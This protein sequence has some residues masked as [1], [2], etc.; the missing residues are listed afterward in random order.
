MKK[1]IKNLRNEIIKL[2]DEND[3][4]IQ[5]NSIGLKFFNFYIYN[6]FLNKYIRYKINFKNC[7]FRKFEYDFNYYPI[8]YSNFYLMNDIINI[9]NTTI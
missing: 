7:T 5:I 4:F 8:E 6:E 1:E 2:F 3:E 9:Y